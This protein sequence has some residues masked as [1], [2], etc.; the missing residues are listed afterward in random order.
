LTFI[1]RLSYY[2][3]EEV[4]EQN[5]LKLNTDL[6]YAKNFEEIIQCHDRF[7]N[8]CLKESLLTNAKLLPLLTADIGSTIYNYIQLKTYL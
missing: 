4:V 2:L 3:S 5:W 7:L 6:Q 8:N 1:K